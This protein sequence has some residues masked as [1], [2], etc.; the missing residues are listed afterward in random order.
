MPNTNCLDG[1]SCPKCG[2]EGP[3]LIEGSAL[4]TVYDDGAEEHSGPDWDD[5]NYCECLECGFK[6]I[7]RDFDIEHMK[8]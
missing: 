8:G 7:M 2:H 6:G 1:M 3:L 5:E 4:F